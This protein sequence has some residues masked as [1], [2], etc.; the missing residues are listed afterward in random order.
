VRVQAFV[1]SGCGRLPSFITPPEVD[2]LREA[3]AEL[4]SKGSLDGCERPNNTLV[5]LRWNHELVEAVLHSPSRV[6]RVRSACGATDLRWISGYISVK[7][8]RSDALWWHQDWWCWDHPVSFHDRAPQ[9]A[10]LCYLDDTTAKSG[11][12][13]VLPGSHRASTPLHALLPEAHRTSAGSLGDQ[14]PASNCR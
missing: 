10:R 3:V 2:E 6:Q 1:R 4:G 5:P 9:V 11:A 14:N 13:R 12:L 7:E 8:P